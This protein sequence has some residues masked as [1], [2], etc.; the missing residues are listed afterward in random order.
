MESAKAQHSPT[1]IKSYGLAIVR[2][3]EANGF[4]TDDVASFVNVEKAAANSPMERMTTSQVAELFS[5]CVELT[6]NPAFGLTV[7]KYMHASTMHALGYSLQASSTLRDCCER[8][9]AYSKLLSEQGEMRI[10]ESGNDFRLSTHLITAGVAFESVDAWHA[11]LIRMFR[12]LYRP[13][14]APKEVMLARPCP[15]GF[16]HHYRRSFQVVVQFDTAY[17]EI[18]IDRN[19]VD[20]PLIGG[21]REIAQHNDQIIEQYIAALNM[22]DIV[23]RTRQIIVRTLSSG[24]CNKQRVANELALSTS[25][26]QQKL[27]RENT[28]FQ[29]LLT[30]VRRSLAFAY[31]A[32]NDQPHYSVT[33]IGFL[34]GFSDTSSFTRAF[35]KWTGKSPREYR[36]ENTD[37]RNST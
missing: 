5:R 6:G 36:Q 2:A 34:L 35:G 28:S 25:S 14:F 11:F 26:L 33:E 31:L 29:E 20:E 32:N 15:D 22:A 13:D 17:S 16:G 30:E 24:N 7:A 12:L 21:N 4:S 23:G 10:E 9:I 37:E 18:C 19:I 8:L 1:T 3:L 27:A